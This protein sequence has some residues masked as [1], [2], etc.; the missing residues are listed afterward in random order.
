LISLIRLGF[1]FRELIGS[2]SSR[3][4][5]A[6]YRGSL[7]GKAWLILQP[8]AY[9]AI[10]MVVF[11]E[12]FKSGAQFK[13][14]P[15]MFFPLAMFAG[16]IPWLSFAESI[17][18]GS[19]VILQGGNL[20][21][22]YAFPSEILPMTVVLVTMF[23]AL[24]GFSLL[25][26]AVYFLLGHAPRMLWLFPIAL[27]LQG[28]FSLGFIYLLSSVLVYVRDLAQM[29]PMVLTF[30]FFMSPIFM[31]AKTPETP[32]VLRTILRYNPM[33]YLISIYREIFVWTPE[34]MREIMTGDL[35]TRKQSIALPHTE[36]GAVPWFELMV[37]AICAF[38][39]LLIGL[40]VF[41]K[42]KPGFPDEV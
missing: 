10:Y 9:L 3:E 15:K 2:L 30:W 26:I 27:V 22:K 12:F 37:F 6:R 18:G 29:I 1:R 21:K 36:P 38:S 28:I 25:G 32:E 16:L 4:L 17:Q 5:K 40:K 7:L 13:D 8:L 34:M 11:G 33:T 35:E 42:L 41:R 23:S 14:A 39:I 20:L 24:V 31:F 19:G